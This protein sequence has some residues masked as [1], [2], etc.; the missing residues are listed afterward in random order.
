MILDVETEDLIIALAFARREC[1]IARLE[2]SE[3]HADLREG[4]S[5]GPKVPRQRR[6]FWDR[7][8]PPEDHDG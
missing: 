8:H 2:I 5:E 1:A 6:P 7:S 4:V 3:T